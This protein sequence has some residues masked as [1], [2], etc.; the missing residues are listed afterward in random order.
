MT[1]EE[2]IRYFFDSQRK[3]L[4]ANGALTQKYTKK[5][6]SI[7]FI[8]PVFVLAYFPLLYLVQIE[9]QQWF[10]NLHLILQM[11]LLVIDMA[12]CIVLIVI[13]FMALEWLTGKMK[14][15]LSL[16]PNNVSYQSIPFFK[17]KKILYSDISKIEVKT[18][19]IL[20]IV[21]NHK[22]KIFSK[23]GTTISFDTNKFDD[24]NIFKFFRSIF[25]TK[26]IDSY[27]VDM[28]NDSDPNIILNLCARLIKRDGTEHYEY[29]KEKGMA[30]DYILANYFMG[31]EKFR[32]RVE[33]RFD[34]LMSSK[35]K[36][37]THYHIVTTQLLKNGKMRYE[38]RHSLFDL[39]FSLAYTSNGVNRAELEM[40]HG[41][42]HYLLIQEWDITNLEYKY[43]CRKREQQAETQTGSSETS[44]T[45][46]NKA[47]EELGLKSDATLDDIK[48]AYRKLVKSCH[49]D[50]L[51]EKCSDDER[52]SAVA[53][54]RA[55]TEAY[56]VLLE[57]S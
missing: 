24:K 1:I 55:I 19:K 28:N 22:I 6:I 20:E 25:R 31:E 27:D 15:T 18:K 48:N 54:F 45:L 26:V 4:D 38:E 52:E 42:G 46:L 56:N 16:H 14:S 12:I 30:I 34:S 51:P 41:I 57:K 23:N 44:N 33:N 32:K 8:A 49:P 3:N 10:R 50:T 37:Q 21:T 53:R 9:H 29:S 40:L 2:N 43:E 11:P 35:K 47:Y 36:K 39:L 7:L 17:R 5:L 13:P